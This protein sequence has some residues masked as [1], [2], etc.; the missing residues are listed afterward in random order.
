MLKWEYKVVDLIK[1][2]GKE[3]IKTTEIPGQ[4]VR[5]LDIEDILNKFGEQGWELVDIQF[6]FEKEEPILVGFFKRHL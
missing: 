3:S 6:L 1:E 5:A 4:W 2:M